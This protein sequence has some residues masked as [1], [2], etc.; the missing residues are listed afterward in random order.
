[1]DHIKTKIPDHAA[2]CR[3]RQK[4][5][6]IAKPLHSLGVFEEHIVQLAGIYGSSEFELQK[7]AVVV[8]C[9][10]NGVVSEGVT[11]SD[12]SVTFTVAES[13]AEGRANINIIAKSVGADVYI[14]D[15]GMITDSENENIITKKAANGTN[16]IAKGA[17][18]SAEQCR[19]AIKTGVDMVE[20]LSAE[21]VSIIA[22]GEMGIG[23]TTTSSAMASVL[24]G[25]APTELTGRG[26]G[27]SDEGFDRKITVIRRAIEVNKPNPQN[28]FEVLQKLGGFDIA[29]MTGTF[30]GGMLYSTPIVV[31][32]FISTVAALT[33][34]RMIPE[35][36][37]YIIASH[38]SKEPAA[39]CVLEALG[40]KA[41]IHADMCLGEGTGAAML[42]P[43]LDAAYAEY[44]SAHTFSDIKLEPYMP[45]K[46]RYI[47]I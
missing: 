10:D 24:L 31:D 35:C 7:K 27:L 6:S 20:R 3:A 2:M 26:A 15:V 46:S 36:G 19:F 38:I 32:G 33:A 44:M 28:A 41:V 5:D 23:N 40:K 37:P 42:F 34:V 4:W 17:A 29:A 43:L 16:N 11:Q 21:G 39:S 30:I 9:S 13:M 18:M 22:T 1:M 14:A 8:Y 45:Q 12:S 25:K 47:K